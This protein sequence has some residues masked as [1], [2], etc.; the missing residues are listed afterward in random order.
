MPMSSLAEVAQ[1]TDRTIHLDPE[2]KARE[3]PA[4][5]NVQPDVKVLQTLRPRERWGGIARLVFVTCLIAAGIGIYVGVKRY[6]Q[7]TTPQ[8]RTEPC[9]RGDLVVT[10]AATGTLDP[11]NLVEI[12]CEISGTI[13]T[14]EVDVNDPV[15][16]GDLLFALDTQELEAQVAKSRATLAVRKAELQLA[17]ATLLES[18]QILGRMEKLQS[19]RASSEQEVDTATANVARAKANISSS[20]AQVSVAQAT[21]DGDLSKLEKSRIYSPIDGIVLTR[22]VEPGQTVAATFQTPVLLTICDDLRRMK[23]KVDVD[24]ADVGGVREGQAATFTVDAY[25]NESFPAR[26]TSLRYASRRVQDV[27]TYEAVLE[28]ANE[29]LK[30]RP[31]MTAVADIITS[32]IQDALLIP[33]AALRYTPNDNSPEVTDGGGESLTSQVW[34]VKK[35]RPVPLP[36]TTGIS[37]G[38]FTEST[39]GGVKEGMPL[40]VDVIP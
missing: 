3:D 32:K 26:I 14:V 11:T 22:K 24:E 18:E 15:K 30:L 36:V 7:P 1:T 27:V 31:G 28:V 25:P 8:Y 6:Y 33:N 21:L 34:I 19:Q 9:R 38:R 40:V 35:N 10:I 5:P 2:E 37:D 20:T 16:A 17:K 39:S 12:G 13:R 29:E 23:L 4:V